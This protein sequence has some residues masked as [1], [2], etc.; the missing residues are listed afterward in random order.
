[1]KIGCSTIVIWFIFSILS[2]AQSTYQEAIAAGD[3]A[4]RKG[5][6][7]AAINYYF[8][9]EAFDPSKKT[10]VKSAKNSRRLIGNLAK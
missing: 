6:F 10:V 3:Q 9:A 7:R 2:I 5:D 4:F 8:A 1:M